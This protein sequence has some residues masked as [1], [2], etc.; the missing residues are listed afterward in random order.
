MASPIDSSVTGPPDAIPAGKLIETVQVTTADGI[1]KQ[2]EVV[3]VADPADPLARGAVLAT[4]PAG[5]EYGQVVRIVGM[6]EL[7]ELLRAQT[8]L[9]K[10]IQMQLSSVVGEPLVDASILLSDPS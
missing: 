5:S 10:S 9:L 4:I 2:R 8:L 1:V 7:T 6:A 3:S